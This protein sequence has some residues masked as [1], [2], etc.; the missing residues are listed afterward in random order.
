MRRC[1]RLYGR[2]DSIDDE[3]QFRWDERYKIVPA[4]YR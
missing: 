3:P 1:R 4:G 2:P